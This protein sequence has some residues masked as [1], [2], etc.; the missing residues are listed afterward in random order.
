MT[1]NGVMGN[2]DSETP[3]PI[4]RVDGQPW[5]DGYTSAGSISSG[6][7]TPCTDL[8]PLTDDDG[9]PVT[10]FDR[11]VLISPD[12]TRPVLISPDLSE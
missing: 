2:D 10:L 9:V 5:L 1:H 3:G 7:L 8:E 11:P 6:V 4:T 12:L